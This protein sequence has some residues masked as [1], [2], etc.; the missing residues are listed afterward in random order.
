M[1]GSR[2]HRRSGKL[3]IFVV[4]NIFAIL[5]ILWAANKILPVYM[6]FVEASIAQWVGRLV[7]NWFTALA[8]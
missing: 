5:S 8:F 3:Y 1:G 4:E 6:Q 2:W 7:D